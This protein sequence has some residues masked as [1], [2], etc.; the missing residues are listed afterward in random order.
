V[1][2]NAPP[3]FSAEDGGMM[4]AIQTKKF[5]AGCCKIGRISEEEEDNRNNL[6]NEY[7]VILHVEGNT[8]PEWAGETKI[9][10]AQLIIIIS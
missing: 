7:D 1:T 2:T 6:A 4:T 5:K 10:E 9:L 3:L 8:A